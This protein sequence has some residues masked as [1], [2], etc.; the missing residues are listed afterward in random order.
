[1][2]SEASFKDDHLH[3]IAYTSIV[4]RK[5]TLPAIFAASNKN[6]PSNAISGILWYEDATGRIVQVL[7]GPRE[8]LQALM[9]KLYAD[10]RHFQ[11]DVM[12]NR[13]L[14]RR[15]YASFGMLYGVE[16]AIADADAA[17]QQAL[18]KADEMVANASDKAERVMYDVKNQSSKC[19]A[20]VLET[21]RRVNYLQEALRVLNDERDYAQQ[22]LQR[23]LLFQISKR[24]LIEREVASA[25]MQIAIRNEELF[26]AGVNQT[27]A[28]ELLTR[29]LEK[30]AKLE[31][32][33]AKLVCD[34][35]RAADAVRSAAHTASE[36]ALSRAK[37]K[38]SQK[39]LS[40]A[41]SADS[42]LATLAEID[43]ET[44]PP[45]QQ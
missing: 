25:R 13:P 27:R 44:R 21:Q 40:M 41:H 32:S 23:T 36:A 43:E 18:Q 35:Q 24:R 15:C 29:Q 11:M 38:A 17:L 45:R 1:M 28:L 42:S 14:A 9:K 16:A 22:R 34:A 30:Q 37:R 3:T 10:S 5:D 20:A 39:A 12:Y 31:A 2:A 8:K 19:R 26:E 7:E 4:K 33:A 6:N